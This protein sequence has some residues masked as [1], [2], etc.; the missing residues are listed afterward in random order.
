MLDFEQEY[1]FEPCKFRIPILE[2]IR[3]SE[4]LFDYDV[5]QL[6]MERKLC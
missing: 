2:T 5:A 6:D 3:V 4:S 1:I